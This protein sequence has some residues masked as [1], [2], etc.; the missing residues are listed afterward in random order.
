[1]LREAP[2]WTGVGVVLLVT[3]VLLSVFQEKFLTYVNIMDILGN[4]A[5][6]MLLAL[7]STYLLLTGLI[8]LSIGSLVGLGSMLLVGMMATGM[9][10]VLS[11]TATLVLITAVSVGFTGMLIVKAGMSFFVVGL[12]AMALLRAIA[13]I[14]TSGLSVPLTGKVG[15][16]TVIWLGSGRVLGIP[17]SAII[18]TA[19]V[20]ASLVVL[21]H[22][23]FGRSLFA[24]GSN[25]DAA[26]LSGIPVDRALL[27]AFAVNGALVVIAA[28]LVT[29]RSQIASPEFG[30]GIELG[31]IAAVLLGGT[32]FQGGS[33]TIVGTVIGVLFIGVLNNGLILLGVP[34]F[35]QGV[36]TGG[37]LLVA[38]GI[39][40][41]RA[42]GTS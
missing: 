36:V 39:D 11:L 38:V 20:L 2:P 19:A 21:S 22:T 34:V 9:P 30:V 1:M 42:R 13:Q 32:S 5:A 16:E 8:D 23:T 33:A 7:G 14:P 17:V 6:T 3:V 41:L 24:I 15:A 27:A 28:V 25:R 31:V 10:V 26:R 29:G 12:G 35:W 40:R 18:A 4:S 37:V